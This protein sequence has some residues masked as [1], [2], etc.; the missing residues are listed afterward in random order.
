[1]SKCCCPLCG[2]EVDIGETLI[3]EDRGIIVRDGKGARLEPMQMRVFMELWDAKP[4]AV[5]YDRLIMRMYDVP[6]KDEPGNALNVLR[7]LV[8][9]H[10]KPELQRVGMSI[11]T[12]F[13]QGYALNF[14]GREAR[15]L[16]TLRQEIDALADQRAA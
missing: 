4:R 10:M 3:V 12:A 13:K 11:D 14:P 15:V 2:G 1:M 5:A 6:G 7:V 8:N 16:R 9:A